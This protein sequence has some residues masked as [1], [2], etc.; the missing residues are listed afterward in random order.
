M[1]SS[2]GRVS[3]KVVIDNNQLAALQRPG[4]M[5]NQYTKGKAETVRV[6]AR[7]IVPVKSGRL[8][9]SIKVEQART[10]IGRYESGYDVVADA[11]S[12]RGFGYAKTVHDGRGPIEGPLMVFQIGS[13][14][15]FTHKVK[16]TR[17]QPFLTDAAR[18][19]MNGT[20]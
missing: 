19:V 17:P 15:I 20:R 6:K 3:V 2:S 14:T 5:V 7:Q 11:R 1:A 16:G 8:R 12:D 4:R 18:A 13:Q 10:D 9:D